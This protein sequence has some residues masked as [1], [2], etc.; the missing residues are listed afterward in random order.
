MS[1]NPVL[2]TTK[3]SKFLIVIFKAMNINNQIRPDA[4]LIGL[5]KFGPGNRFLLTENCGFTFSARSCLSLSLP[6]ILKPINVISSFH[7]SHLF[8]GRDLQIIA[9]AIEG[10]VV[11]QHHLHSDE[12]QSQQ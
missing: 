3:F 8:L 4:S 11:N 9:S 6:V 12:Q 5:V 1:S 7:I 2:F 10:D